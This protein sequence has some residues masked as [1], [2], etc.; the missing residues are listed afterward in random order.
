MTF[1]V[2]TQRREHGEVP[3]HV[4]RQ[5]RDLGLG[6]IAD[7]DAFDVREFYR[8]QLELWGIAPD[9]SR[10]DRSGHLTPPRLVGEKCQLI[11][12]KCLVGWNT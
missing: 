5:L 6:D 7:L 12:K 8:L 1:E 2:F 11:W 3:G 4:V 10:S 9:P